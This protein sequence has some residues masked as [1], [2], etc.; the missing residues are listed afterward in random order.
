MHYYATTNTATEKNL[1][2]AFNQH[3]Q[4]LGKA[5]QPYITSSAVSLS[6][7][8]THGF[9][10]GITVTCPGFYGPQGRV[11]RAPLAQDQLI[12]QLTTFKHQ[13]H[14]VSNFEMETSAIYG[15][16]NLLGH[17][18][19]S[20][21]AIVANRIQQSFSSDGNAAVEHMIKTCLP[22]IANL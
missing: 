19:L 8:F 5:I 9:H 11:L 22:I 4:L 2:E 3:T 12:N 18:A 20:I 21:S 15:L 10:H 1:L 17:Q 13:E 7:Q 6:A 14:F 16:A